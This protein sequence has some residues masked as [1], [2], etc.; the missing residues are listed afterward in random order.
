M[1]LGRRLYMM[2]KAITKILKEEKEYSDLNHCNMKKALKYKQKCLQ[3]QDGSMFL[4]VDSL[5]QLNNLMIGANNTE[6]RKVNVKPA[7]YPIYCNPHYPWY[8]VESTL[9]ILLD[10]FNDRFIANKAFCEQFMQINL[11]RRKWKNM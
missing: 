4:T 7:G 11:F 8:C 10:K 5:I 3:N 9:H 2:D 6:L 1:Q